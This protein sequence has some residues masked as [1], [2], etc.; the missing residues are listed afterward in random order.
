LYIVVIYIWTKAKV[1][2]NENAPFTHA[3]STTL[4][5]LFTDFLHE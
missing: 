4:Q 1:L 5:L 2:A 3:D